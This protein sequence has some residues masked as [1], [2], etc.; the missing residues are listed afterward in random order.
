MGVLVKLASD[1]SKSLA[2]CSGNLEV[3]T[4]VKITLN[5]EHRREPSL[6]TVVDHGTLDQADLGQR[7]IVQVAEWRQV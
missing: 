3:G 5:P 7:H 6:A 2:W 1:T 4:Q